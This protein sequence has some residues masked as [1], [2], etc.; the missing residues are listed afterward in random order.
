M[1]N[2]FD[3]EAAHWDKQ[4]YRLRR[5]KRFAEAIKDSL[6]LKKNFKGLDFGCGTGLLGF[7]FLDT[8][9]HMTF[10]DSSEG[11]I[12]QVNNKITDNS[13]AIGQICDIFTVSPAER[14]DLIV[15]LQALHHVP[16]AYGA[17]K[18][19]SEMTMP[20]GYL[21]LADLVEEDGSFHGEHL[22]TAHNGFN[23]AD[24]ESHLNGLGLEKVST[25]YPFINEKVIDGEKKQFPLFLLIYKK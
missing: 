3:V 6:P 16:D 22:E 25:T 14:F 15:T 10:W 19:L 5:T 9:N 11:M 7:N 20:G 21:C 8:I 4:Q 2:Q 24:L 1:K 23:V 12:E 13:R 17:V 18:I